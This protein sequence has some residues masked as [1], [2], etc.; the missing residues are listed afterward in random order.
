MFG[1]IIYD[2]ICAFGNLCLSILKFAL[3]M[4]L[5]LLPFYLIHLIE[6]L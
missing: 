3:V 6:T 5:M 1:L 2:T 4:A